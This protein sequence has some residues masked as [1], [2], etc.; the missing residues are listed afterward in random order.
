M[1]GAA[2]LKENML[3]VPAHKRVFGM[4]GRLTP[5]KRPFDMVELA[6]C[7]EEEFVWVGTGE[8]S[9]QFASAAACVKN[10]LYLEARDDVVR[11]MKC[12]KGLS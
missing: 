4:F 9:I 7:P 8:L 12:S 1:D 6:N 2:N 10:M 5:Q 3:S 11:F